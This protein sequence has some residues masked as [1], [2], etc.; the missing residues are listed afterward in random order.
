MGIPGPASCSLARLISSTS[1]EASTA[2][3][4]AA[5][6]A[7][8]TVHRPVPH[9]SSSTLPIGPN[10]SSSWRTRS[11]SRTTCD[12]TPDRVRD[13]P[14]GETTRRTPRR[15]PGSR[16]AALRGAHRLRRWILR[17]LLRCLGQLGLYD[18][19]L[20][21]V[22]QCAGLEGEYVLAWQGI[23]NL[24]IRRT[25]NEGLEDVVGV[26]GTVS[27]GDVDLVAADDVAQ[28]P[29]GQ[30]ALGVWVAQPVAR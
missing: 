17:R 26:L 1:G 21:V 24:G 8:S 25:N 12:S 23:C 30:P 5:C 20:A 16:L 2:V 11:S 4:P 27:V 7:S 9:A 22:G 29:E 14:C 28:V 18:Q 15:V 10:R 19:T 3:M 6:R 13:V